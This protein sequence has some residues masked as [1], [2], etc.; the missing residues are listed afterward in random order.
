MTEYKI[1]IDTATL[2]SLFEDIDLETPENDQFEQDLWEKDTNLGTENNVHKHVEVCPVVK[3]FES[4]RL[5]KAIPS[6]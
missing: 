3:A 6:H 5:E 2:E 4:Q 1:Y